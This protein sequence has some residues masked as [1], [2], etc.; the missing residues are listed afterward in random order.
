VLVNNPMRVAIYYRWSLVLPLCLPIAV[1]L[2][3]VPLAP[4]LNS[5]PPPLATPIMILVWSLLA[6]GVPY[7][8][9]ACGLWFW[10]RGKSERGLRRIAYAAPLVMLGVYALCLLALSLAIEPEPPF[11]SAWWIDGTLVFFAYSAMLIMLLGY[12]Y[13]VVVDG[14]RWFLKRKGVVV[15]A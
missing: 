2:A 4:Y 12:L 13:V 10:M 9:S 6:G 11:T 15:E 3:L 1:I 8:I 5:L 7:V 14:L